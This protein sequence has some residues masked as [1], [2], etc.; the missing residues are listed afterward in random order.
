MLSKKEI[1]RI[2][3]QKEIQLETDIQ[4][5]KEERNRFKVKYFN[6][7][8][9]INKLNADI[10]VVREIKS[11]EI[12]PF[13]IMIKSSNHDSEATANI[14]MSDLHIEEKVDP[15]TVNNLNEYNPQIAKDRI[16]TLFNNGLR[17]I[18]IQRHGVK[19]DNLVLAV[20]G[21]LI[22][23]NIH[24]DI[25]EN[26][27]MSAT[28]AILYVQDILISG[29]NFLLKNGN[30]KKIYVICKYGNHSRTTIDKRFSTEYKTNY[31][32]L[33]FHQVKKFF[34]NNNRVEIIIPISY[35]Y[36]FNIYSHV[37]RFHHGDGVL[38]QGGVG[39]ITIPVNK[40]IAQWNKSQIAHLDIFGH[41]HQFF[42]GGNFIANGSCIGYNA[43]ALKN[44]FSYEKPRQAFFLIDKKRGKT[45]VCPI[46][47]E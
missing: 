45:V 19:I 5:Y 8:K 12:K 16:S 20:L 18:E 24:D 21:D 22:S 39:G 41:F 33:L 35:L 26:S 36:Y 13:N 17:L 27:Y 15:R 3:N 42:D 34:D 2:K 29:I 47:L 9:E 25:K 43:Y 11:H 31:E 28:E 46:Y 38:Y 4:K 7:L 14:I 40:A 32:W 23:G 1:D 44:K 10:D 6:A 37:L 30:F